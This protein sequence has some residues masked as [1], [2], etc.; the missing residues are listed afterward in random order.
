LT[1]NDATVLVQ[2]ECHGCGK[3]FRVLYA[4]GEEHSSRWST[5]V[6][7]PHCR[8]T[9]LLLGCAPRAASVVVVGSA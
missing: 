4:P 3:A 2:L 5:P 8:R 9:Q 7:C 1:I 6:R